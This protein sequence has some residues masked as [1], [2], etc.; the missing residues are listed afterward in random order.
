MDFVVMALA[1]AGL[2]PPTDRVLDGRDPTATLSGKAPSPHEFMCW[3]FGSRAKAIR[4]GNYK[5]IKAG[6]ART[7]EW[8]LFDLSTDIGE[9][10]NLAAA[11]PEVV[12]ELEEK[13]NRWFE[14]AR[15]GR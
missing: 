3:Q 12:R 1:A 5:L 9:T 2:Q 6:K 8:Q 4:Q 11:K 15:S 14:D 13:F 7:K 10:Y